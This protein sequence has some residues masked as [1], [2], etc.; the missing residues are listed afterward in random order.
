MFFDCH[1]Q[2]LPKARA[3]TRRRR[4]TYEFKKTAD[5]ATMALKDGPS[6][7]LRRNGRRT[8]QKGPTVV[9]SAGSNRGSSKR[10]LVAS[11]RQNWRKWSAANG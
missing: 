4:V 1:P 11:A 3:R 2:K 8:T 7:P 5:R 6:G 10:K 9:R